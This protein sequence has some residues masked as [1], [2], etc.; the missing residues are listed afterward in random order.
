MSR[1]GAQRRTP[2]N[3]IQPVRD[4]ETMLNPAQ[5]RVVAV[6][7]RRLERMLADQRRLL[8]PEA[9]LVLS[10]RILDVSDD[11]AAELRSLTAEVLREVQEIASLCGLRTVQESTRRMLQGALSVQWLTS[12]TRAPRSCAA[13]ARSPRRPL[14]TWSRRS[15]GSSNCYRPCR[16]RWRE[17]PMGRAKDRSIQLLPELRESCAGGIVFYGDCVL[18]LQKSC[19]DWVWP[20]GHIEPGESAEDAAQREVW[21]ETRIEARI[22]GSVGPT[23][24]RFSRHGRPCAK[25]VSWFA[26]ETEDIRGLRPEPIFLQEEFVTP[27]EAG[28]RLT[29]ANDRALVEA[30]VRLRRDNTTTCQVEDHV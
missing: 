28:R 12:W 20:K 11:V 22:I 26:M 16:R 15:T 17:S 13:T 25:T 4:A 5:H 3:A 6:T 7:L 18:I 21:E 14:P 29:F 1:I 10:E 23:R 8:E 30:A 27:A 24:F 2:P 19:G 9:P